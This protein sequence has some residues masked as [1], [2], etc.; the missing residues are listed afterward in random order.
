[1]DG[2]IQKSI[3]LS[4]NGIVNINDLAEGIYIIKLQTETG[5]IYRKFIK[6]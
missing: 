1:M 2:K 5:I 6:Q 3:T 4:D